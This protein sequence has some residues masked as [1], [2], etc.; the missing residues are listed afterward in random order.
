LKP[1]LDTIT[2]RSIGWTPKHDFAEGLAATLEQPWSTCPVVP[3]LTPDMTHAID[4]EQAAG[5]SPARR[6][7]RHRTSTAA[8]DPACGGEPF[9]FFGARPGNEC[10]HLRRNVAG[11][12]I[13]AETS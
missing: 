3:M 9:R 12:F 2:L 8:A 11:R 4:A 10:G 7:A 13:E 1:A 5:P 6:K